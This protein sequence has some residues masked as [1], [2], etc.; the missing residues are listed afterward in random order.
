MKGLVSPSCRRPS[1]ASAITAAFLSCVTV[2]VLGAQ[3]LAAS[4][5]VQRVIDGDTLVVAGIG[6]VRLIGVDTPE[7]VDSRKP[8]QF[9]AMEASAFTK[10][11]AEGQTV[12][13]EFEGSRKDRYNRTRTCISRTVGCSTQI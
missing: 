1:W 3:G 4:G 12:R 10:R 5:R 7:T 13:L 9:Y 2:T 11:H 8:V 6:T